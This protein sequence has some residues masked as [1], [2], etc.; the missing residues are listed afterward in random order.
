[1]TDRELLQMALNALERVTKEMLALKDALAE[2]GGRPVS[3]K[4]YQYLWDSSHDAYVDVA[5]PAGNI[6]CNR[7]EQPELEPVG[8]V[9]DAYDTTGIEWNC[10]DAP[11]IGTLLYTAPPQRDF[12]GLTDKER[13]EICLGDEAIARAIEQALRE[14]NNG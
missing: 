4:Q 7:L 2:R 5:L 9:Y 3:N 11:A 1:M 6:I 12:I 8:T 10:K 14:K 13:D